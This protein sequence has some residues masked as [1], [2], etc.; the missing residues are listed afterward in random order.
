MSEQLA[1]TTNNS[2]QIDTAVRAEAEAKALLLREQTARDLALA[3]ISPE[4]ASLLAKEKKFELLQR[5][6]MLLAKSGMFTETVRVKDESGWTSVVIDG[7]QAIAR[8]ATRVLLG[9]S[10]G[11]GSAE[12]MMA[13]DVIEGRPAIASA[14]RASRTQIKGGIGWDIQWHKR[15]NAI[16][17]CSLHLKYMATNKPV[18]DPVSGE[19]AVVSFTEED[20]R[21][22]PTTIYIEG[23]K[24]TG[25]LADKHNYKATPANMYFAR[26][27]ANVQRFYAPSALNDTPIMSREEALDASDSGEVIELKRSST[28]D[29]VEPKRSSTDFVEP[30][31]TNLASSMSAEALDSG[32]DSEKIQK[33]SAESSEEQKKSSGS[34]TISITQQ[35]QM[36]S[37]VFERGKKADL[38][39]I[40]DKFGYMSIKQVT[41]DKFEDVMA[42]IAK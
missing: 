14:T 32:A 13:I 7:P 5:E 10:M 4:Y 8:A 40:L 28:G 11:L 24:T 3:Q 34:G 19:R 20:A 16:V 31:T 41:L 22:I 29:F 35:G 33:T 26:A 9:D 37:F 6:A 17:G 38:P 30:S 21:R 12:S 42:E 36:N 23:K 18:I 15:D 2:A 1:T 39:A 27:A 25:T